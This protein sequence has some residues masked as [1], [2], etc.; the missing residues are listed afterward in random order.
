MPRTRVPLP[1]QV[2]RPFEVYLNSVRQEPGRDFTE[3][4]G[5]LVFERDLRKDRVSGWRWLIGSFGFS[6]Y[7]QDDSVDVRYERADGS[8]AVAERLDFEADAQG[9]AD[10]SAA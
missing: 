7:R 9:E 1:P 5:A 4:D 10:T 3:E 6:T 2:R 8:P